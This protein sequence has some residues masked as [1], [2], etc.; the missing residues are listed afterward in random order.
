MALWEEFLEG[1][2]VTRGTTVYFCQGL[3]RQTFLR[4]PWNIMSEAMSQSIRAESHGGFRE[5]IVR[6][7]CC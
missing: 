7:E 3:H 1:K 6:R 5:Q 4:K 2:G